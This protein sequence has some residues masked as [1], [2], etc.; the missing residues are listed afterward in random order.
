MACFKGIFFKNPRVHSFSL[1]QWRKRLDL[2]MLIPLSCPS[3]KLP[4]S[5]VTKER[6][7]ATGILH[8]CIALKTKFPEFLKTKRNKQKG[9]IRI[10][11][12]AFNQV[13][14]DPR[15]PGSSQP[16]PWRDVLVI[17]FRLTF[18]GHVLLTVL[19]HELIIIVITNHLGE[20]F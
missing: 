10:R 4:S 6:L 16:S 18:A 15:H 9:E 19:G 2:N 13:R 8:L 14:A 1:P 12:A 3:L 20:T 17:N 7:T 11:E 5:Q